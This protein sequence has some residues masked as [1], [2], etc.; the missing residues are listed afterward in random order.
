MTPILQIDSVSR[1]F[2]RRTVIDG[3]SLEVQS[4]E[5][6]S[7][8][9]PNGSGKSTLARLAAGLLRPHGGAVRIG[10]EDPRLAAEARRRIGYLGHA[11]LL[12]GDLTPAQNL[13]FVGQLYGLADLDRT[14]AGR[15]DQL[16]VGPERDTPVRA[17]S[18]GMTQR[19]ALAR[20]LLHRPSLLI[21]DEPFTGL[22]LAS[23]ARTVEAIRAAVAE[24]A[25]V[26]LISHELTEL[27]RLTARIHVLARG[28][29]RATADTSMALEAFRARYAESVDG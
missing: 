10:G 7:L 16:G 26:V 1:R 21:W 9:G 13:H 25:A 8:V 24:G 3:V 23:A 28:V 19:V 4:G 5:I 18:R 20:S 6:H 17:L 14:I 22:D 12:Y 15:F 2:G 29:L 27:W 11:S